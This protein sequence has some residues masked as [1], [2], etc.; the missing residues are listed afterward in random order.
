[1]NVKTGIG[2]LALLLV[3]TAPQDEKKTACMNNLTRLWKH[4]TDYINQFGGKYKKMPDATG[5]D[6]WL[7][8]TKTDPPI[9]EEKDCAIL[10]CPLSKDKPKAGFTNY[11]GPA[12]KVSELQAGDAVGC[13]EPGSHPDGTITVLTKDGERHLVGP[14]DLLY[15]KAMETT[16]GRPK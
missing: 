3:G 5:P 1:M 7:A 10:V 8:L 13:C 4:Q 2:F 12:K 16:V 9:L 15:K 11:R 6:F 14:D